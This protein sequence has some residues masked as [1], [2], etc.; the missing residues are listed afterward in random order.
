MIGQQIFMEEKIKV[1]LLLMLILRPPFKTR[2]NLLHFQ[3]LEQ[4]LGA[5]DYP[6]S[7]LMLMHNSQDFFFKRLLVLG[8][9]KLHKKI[10]FVKQTRMPCTLIRFPELLGLNRSYSLTYATPYLTVSMRCSFPPI[11]SFRLH[12]PRVCKTIQLDISLL[13]E[14]QQGTLIQLKSRQCFQNFTF[15]FPMVGQNRVF[16]GISPG[17]QQ[18]GI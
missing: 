12:P 14:S 6:G 7:S 11:P 13:V 18:V 4:K 16:S 5:F 10:H 3:R 8:W 9:I 1:P 2:Q 15:T 17:Q